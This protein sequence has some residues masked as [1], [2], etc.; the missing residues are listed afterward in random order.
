MD[1][2][3]PV[4]L[5]SASVHP[6]ETNVE[7]NSGA[8]IAAPT[9][10]TLATVA[11]RHAGWKAWRER[12]K[13]ALALTGQ[14]TSRQ[15]AFE[16]C[17]ANAWLSECKEVP[18]TYRIA[19]DR[20]HDRF[21]LPCANE[22]SR[23]T[24]RVISDFIKPKTL[25]FLTLTLRNT[26]QS[27][28]DSLARLVASFRKLRNRPYWKQHVTGGASFIECKWIAQSQNWHPHLHILTEGRFME[29]EKLKTEWYAVTGDSYVIDIRLI[30]DT[31]RAAEYVAKYATKGY[32]SSVFHDQ[33][34]LEEAV[35]ALAGKRLMM[36]FGRWRGFV[37]TDAENPEHWEPVCPLS[38]IRELARAGSTWALALF[39][40][41]ANPHDFGP[42]GRMPA[43]ECMALD[44]PPP[45][46]SPCFL[47]GSEDAKLAYR[48]GIGYVEFVGR[49]SH[50]E[51]SCYNLATPLWT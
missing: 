47:A 27:L 32:S 48:F 20:C 46:N 16:Q 41:L 14:S 25:R 29:R 34:R 37:I 22:R 28:A 45:P 4:P 40:H 2:P 42:P 12:V 1:T 17:G 35:T 10:E 18:G 38:N 43:A 3:V 51:A 8:L 7:P 9:A 11:F 21:C 31:A 36:C 49:T 33:A 39:R 6:P 24:A 50:D 13:T 5:T 23:R 26:G 15:T 30:K 44:K 19:C